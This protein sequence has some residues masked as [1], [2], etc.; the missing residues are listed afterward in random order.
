MKY[1]AT[2]DRALVK[3]S[4]GLRNVPSTKSALRSPDLIPDDHFAV[5]LDIFGHP[6]SSATPVT[7]AGTE[8]EGVLTAF[9]MRW[10]AGEV[11]DLQAG[12]R[13]VDRE[14]DTLLRR[15]TAGIRRLDLP[16]A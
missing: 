3:L 15:A 11:D 8:Y 1:L 16:A 6:K 4:N 7:A 10:Q 14:I 2:D 5:F 9:A 13:E 12:L